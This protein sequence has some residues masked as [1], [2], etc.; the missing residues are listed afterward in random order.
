MSQICVAI[1]FIQRF[2]TIFPEV[3]AVV[4]LSQLIHLLRRS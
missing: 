4:V 2:T 1:I 3:F